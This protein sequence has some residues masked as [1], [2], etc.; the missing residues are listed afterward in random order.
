MDDLLEAGRFR[1]LTNTFEERSIGIDD[2]AMWNFLRKS[3]KNYIFAHFRRV[4]G[5]SRPTLKVCLCWMLI[6]EITT[7]TF[8]D[9]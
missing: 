1:R 3:T 8:F 2:I 7:H 4:T 9:T 6:H 5:E